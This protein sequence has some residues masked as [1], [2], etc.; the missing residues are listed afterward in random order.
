MNQNNYKTYTSEPFHTNEQI[1]TLAWRV[2]WAWI[3][4]PKKA[5]DFLSKWLG[6]TSVTTKVLDVLWFKDNI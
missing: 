2:K 5:H 1:I 4:C 3:T 6:Q